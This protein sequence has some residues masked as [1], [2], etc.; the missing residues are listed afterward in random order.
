MRRVAALW[1]YTEF[2][3]MTGIL[4]SSSA[5]RMH[6]SKN[7]AAAVPLH[8][9]L[10]PC[11]TLRKDPGAA[12]GEIHLPYF[13]GAHSHPW[14]GAELPAFPHART[15]DPTTKGSC[16]KEMMPAG[17]SLEEKPHQYLWIT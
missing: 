6:S 15:P 1:M 3:M 9:S 4:A 2:F 13:V 5:F 11:P 7:P 12:E 16:T 14:K 17:R 10:L 8:P